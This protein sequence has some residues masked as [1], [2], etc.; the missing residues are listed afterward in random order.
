MRKDKG[1]FILMDLLKKNVDYCDRFY[2]QHHNILFSLVIIILA[3]S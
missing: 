2:P 1:D 3:L